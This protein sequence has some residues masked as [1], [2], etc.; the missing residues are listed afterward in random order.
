VRGQ[1]ITGLLHAASCQF[2]LCVGSPNVSFPPIPPSTELRLRASWRHP[3]RA[4]IRSPA[5]G[6]GPAPRFARE[7][8]LRLA[9][10]ALP[11]PLTVSAAS[12]AWRGHEVGP[13]LRCPIERRHLLSAR[14]S[15]R[16]SF[17]FSSVHPFAYTVA[18]RMTTHTL[19]VLGRFNRLCFSLP[20]IACLPSMSQGPVTVR[21]RDV[22]Q[23][24]WRG[25]YGVCEEHVFLRSGP[26]R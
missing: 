21:G 6:L 4:D 24:P 9:Q 5:K 19:S 3:G 2:S 13:H 17:E 16:I 14:R 8:R 22:S 15:C 25:L 10:R 12:L 1:E 23:G 11:L 20:V 7:S 26:S 18:F